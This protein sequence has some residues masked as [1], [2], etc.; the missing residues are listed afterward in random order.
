M[1]EIRIRYS[2]EQADAL[3]DNCLYGLPYG[4]EYGEEEHIAAEMLKLGHKPGTYQCI[5]LDDK[6]LEHIIRLNQP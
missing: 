1:S 3:L 5:A 4:Y 6:N 2:Q